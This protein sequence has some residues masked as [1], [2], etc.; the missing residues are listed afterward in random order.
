MSSC[1]SETHATYAAAP[2][3]SRF[4]SVVGEATNPAESVLNISSRYFH[5]APNVGSRAKWKAVWLTDFGDYDYD[6]EEETPSFF[7]NYDASSEN[8][9]EPVAD[10]TSEGEATLNSSGQTTIISKQPFPDSANR[11]KATVVWQVDVTGPDGQTITGGA[12]DNVTMNDVTL[13][14][15]PI[16]QRPDATLRFEF[17]TVPRIKGAPVPDISTPEALKAAFLA[18]KSVV[19]S[20]DGTRT[21]RPVSKSSCVDE[22]LL[23]E[24]ERDN[25]AVPSTCGS[26]DERA[27]ATPSRITRRVASAEESCGSLSRAIS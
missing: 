16:D 4:P 27:C 8:A 19:R 14:I 11:A 10:A 22:P 18:A 20:T 6:D 21:G 12:V 17:R 7:T 2:A 26:S 15:R 25:V 1:F 13:A 24:R 23:F 3:L 5:G 9:K